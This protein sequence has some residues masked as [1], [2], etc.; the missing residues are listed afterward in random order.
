[1]FSVSRG[2]GALEQQRHD[3]LVIARGLPQARELL[4]GPRV[5]LVLRE[6]LPEDLLGELCV[7]DARLG[8]LCGLASQLTLL[9]GFAL[10]PREVAKRRDAIALTAG[11]APKL[12]E[13]A[14]ELDVLRIR[15]ERLDERLLGAAGVLHLVALPGPEASPEVR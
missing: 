12:L 11:P 14:H 7:A 3:L 4:G 8:E 9:V 2:V 6:E 15:A 5:G 10:E 13:R 1:L